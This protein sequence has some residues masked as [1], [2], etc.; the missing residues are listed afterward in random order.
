M[1]QPIL[2]D[3]NIIVP[4]F[5]PSK[6]RPVWAFSKPGRALEGA[7]M[8]GL[9]HHFCHVSYERML[10]FLCGMEATNQQA[11]D[12]LSRANRSE[13]E[14]V[15]LSLDVNNGTKRVNEMAIRL[16]L[17]R[18]KSSGKRFYASNALLLRLA[19]Q[20]GLL[21]RKASAAVLREH[22]VELTSLCIMKQQTKGM[23]RQMVR[24]VFEGDR[25]AARYY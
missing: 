24:A 10:G 13:T 22:G 20:E 17:R 9:H 14:I 5:D 6:Q 11:F 8:L 23:V 15:H 19:H 12:I 18:M 7:R 25:I 21:V 3:Y 4:T 16:V 1:Q 2:K